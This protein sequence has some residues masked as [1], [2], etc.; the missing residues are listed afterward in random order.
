M[1]YF[2]GPDVERN[3][4]ASGYDVR[5]S[6]FK[7]NKTNDNYLLAF[8]NSFIQLPPYMFLREDSQNNVTQHFGV[9]VE[10]LNWLAA[11]TRTR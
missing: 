8:K 6:T 2:D 7:F 10:V 1:S 5:L 9:I 11:Y 3:I 4:I